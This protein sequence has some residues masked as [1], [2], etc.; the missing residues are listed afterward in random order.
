MDGEEKNTLESNSDNCSSTEIPD[1][2]EK[3]FGDKA[4][5][6]VGNKCEGSP[7]PVKNIQGE[8]VTPVDSESSKD[9]D[10]TFKPEAITNTTSHLSSV[11][12]STA[13]EDILN[14]VKEQNTD[15]DKQQ[16][17]KPDQG[18]DFA[19]ETPREFKKSEQKSKII[20]A[21]DDDSLVIDEAGDDEIKSESDRAGESE[22]CK[23]KVQ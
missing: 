10:V 23:I 1:D 20:T 7:I 21:D 16:E 4:C 9:E 12:E 8:N 17:N 14:A 13:S 22:V 5:K 19:K 15:S 6:D 11:S 18:E 3:K 2:A